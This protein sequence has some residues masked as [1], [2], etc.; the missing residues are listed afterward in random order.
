MGAGSSDGPLAAPRAPPT[1]VPLTVSPSVLDRA[2]GAG[3]VE[4][5][6]GREGAGAGVCGRECEVPVAGSSPVFIGLMYEMRV[7][8]E[9]RASREGGEEAS[10]AAVAVEVAVA[11]RAA[12][13]GAVRRDLPVWWGSMGLG[14]LG[15]C[16]VGGGSAARALRRG[17]GLEAAGAGGEFGL[18]VAPSGFQRSATDKR[19]PATSLPVSDTAPVDG[20]NSSWL[21]ART[22]DCTKPRPFSLL[23]LGVGSFCMDGLRKAGEGETPCAADAGVLGAGWIG[24]A[25]E[26]VEM[27]GVLGLGVAETEG[28][29]D[30]G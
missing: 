8:D 23:M 21:L 19:F 30:G 25:S 11:E 27:E 12:L 1:C 2:P 15:V 29:G 5:D 9:P 28:R 13:E 6:C 22:M 26:G 20:P 10:A 18:E 14:G 17:T 16:C 4:R 24:R 3:V 7:E